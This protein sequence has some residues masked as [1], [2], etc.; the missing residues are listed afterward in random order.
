M[1]Y[2]TL[3]ELTRNPPADRSPIE[4]NWM[5]FFPGSEAYVQYEISPRGGR[6]FAKLLGNGLTS[7]NLTDPEESPCLFD[8]DDNEPDERRKGGSWHQTTNSLRLVLCERTDVSCKPSLDNT[9]FFAVVH[10]KHS[11]ALGLPMR[12]ERYFIVWS[13][14]APFNMLAVSQYPIQMANET[15]TGWSA[16]ENWDG[17]SA[18]LEE[19]RGMWAYFTYTT[20]IAYAWGRKGDE[21]F[22]K[23][24]GYLD[25]VVV[26]SIGV[27][28][29]SQGFARVPAKELLQCM[30]ACPGRI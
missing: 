14:T 21:A 17:D 18:A 6:T 3:T 10:R 25:D 7:T 13:A 4:K 11:N 28:D 16:A 23:G 26:V 24:T 27:D 15:A 30:R 8:V 19:G 1:S 5:L 12:Y 29:M 9:V 22:W 2:P 20:T